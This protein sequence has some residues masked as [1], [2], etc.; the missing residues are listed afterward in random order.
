M[1]AGI[2]FLLVVAIQA[3]LFPPIARVVGAA[4]LA[5]ILVVL[6]LRLQ[7]RHEAT[8]AE[9]GATAARNEATADRPVN[10]GA[11]ALVGTGL[12]AG[13]LDVIAST[14]LYQW[15][16][17]PAAYMF[18]GGLALVGMALAQRWSSAVLACLVTAGTMALAPLISSGIELPIFYVI[19][20]IAAAV[21]AAE[22]G[23]VV[24]LVWSV[25]PAFMLTGY[26]ASSETTGRGDQ[27][28]LIVAAL[29]F[30]AV[31]AGVA[32]Y[33]TFR[34][35]PAAEYAALVVVPGAA[36]L[37]VLPTLDL[38]QPGW[39][40]G[41]LLAAA[42][43]IT[44]VLLGRTLDAEHTETRRGSGL[45]LAAV[46]GSVG[47]VLLV[48]AWAELD[49]PAATGLALT[50][51]GI[52]YALAAGQWPRRWLEWAAGIIAGL[53]LL[54][55]LAV[56]QPQLAL[57]ERLALRD[58]SYIDVVASFA[59]AVLAVAVTR[60]ATRRRVGGA[61]R[62]VMA[63]VVVALA[64]LSVMVVAAGV[65][66]GELADNARG[67]FL[68]AHLVVTV[69]W[70]CCAAWLVLTASPRI[71]DAR[72]LGF[73][74][75]GLALAKLLFL[76]LATL[77]GL[78]RVLSFIVVGA[79]MLAVAVRYRGGDDD[80]AAAGP[81]PPAAGPSPAAGGGPAGQAAG[82]WTPGGGPGWAG[83]PY[84]RDTDPSGRGSPT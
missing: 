81:P 41:L 9:H 6:G 72:T 51:T 76:D 5:V 58:F 23:V 57:S 19:V 46:T 71:A 14:V 32:W 73:V 79:V 37:L 16:P 33:D 21:L 80:A 67:G 1:L 69:L 49:G 59:V 22:L 12:A 18:V 26:L 75:G 83:N 74:L 82:A 38:L 15:V 8:A 27:I 55:Y 61:S 54:T 30:A 29:A 7:A 20:G 50:L 3:G 63:G 4:V 34:R 28:A 48:G 77:P 52:A 2:A 47:S 43:L 53:A 39:P 44:T 66:I 56:N 10:P 35:E 25:P 24:R 42:Y 68:A 60:W 13:M 40:V 78:F 70:I 45:L 36:P 17:V 62:L 11:V 65:V 31:A 64:A 84:R